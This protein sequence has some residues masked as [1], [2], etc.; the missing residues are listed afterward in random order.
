MDIIDY[1]KNPGASNLDIDNFSGQF[2]GA[3]MIVGYICAVAMVFYIAIRYLIARPAEKAQLKTQLT[4]L[5]IGAILL[6]SGTT[7]LGVIAGAFSNWF[8]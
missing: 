6:A 1:F 7:V 5:V 3:V 8:N 4:Y 2:A